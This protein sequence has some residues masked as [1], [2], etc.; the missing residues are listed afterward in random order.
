MEKNL[1]KKLRRRL[2]CVQCKRS[3]RKCDKLRPACSRCQQALLQCIYERDADRCVNTITESSKNSTS[4]ERVNN[5]YIAP[6]ERD[7]YELSFESSTKDLVNVP[8]FIWNVEDMLVILGSMTF[9]DYPFASHSVVEY[10]LY[11]RALCGSLHGMTLIDLSSRLNGLPSQDSLNRVL[12]PL[13]FIEKAIQRRIQFSKANRFQPPV[14]GLLYNGCSVEDDSL[15]D[16]LQTLAVEIE[17]LPMQKKDCDTLLKSFYQNIYPFH[18]FIDINSFEHDL[19]M[20][21]VEDNNHNWKISIDSKDARKKIETMSLLA[22][23]MAITLKHSTLDIDILSIV[24]ESASESAKKLSLLCHRLLCLLDVFRYPNES[25]FGC[26]LYFYISEHLDPDSPEVIVLPTE[27]LG[28]NHLT[29]LSMILGLQ[30][31]PCKYKRIQNPQ[32]IRRRRLLWFGIQSLRFQITL[33]EGNSDKTINEFMEASLADSESTK[34]SSNDFSNSMDEFY[35]QFSN[36]AWEKCKFH[37]L[38]NKLISSYTSIVENPLLFTVLENIRRSEDFM[39]E[40]FPLDLIYSPLNDPALNTVA[41]SKGSILNICDV[42]KTEV[43]MAN[44]VGRTCVFNT[45]NVLSLYFEKKCIIHWE[46][47]ENNYHYFTLRSF[48]VYLEV[49]GL[50]SDYLDTR[51]GGNIP[52]QND[53]VINKQVCFTLIRIW[54]FQSRILLRLSYKQE[55]EIKRVSSNDTQGASN[56]TRI[57]ARLI[58]HVRNQMTYLIGLASER[59]QQC[60]FGNFQAV[61][62]FRYI[63]YVVDAGKL[64]SVT[65]EFWERNIDQRKVPQNIQ[66]TVGL[67]WGLETKNSRAIKQKLTSPQTLESFNELLLRQMEGAVLSSSFGENSNSVVSSNLFEGAFNVNEDET[68]SELLESNFELFCDLL[69]KNMS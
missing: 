24:K 32:H 67:K 55:T 61:E 68:L 41:F 36:I 62:M 8:L 21:F 50:V 46:Q 17:S 38:L 19:A 2:V 45:L 31:D 27:L 43:F 64:V 56:M 65:N 28:L 63:V 18:P 47:Y 12:T 6:Y 16:V 40:H 37:I 57:L 20:L 4:Q 11:L 44:I 3:K 29:N 52:Q 54:L 33:P 59:L 23:I 58:Q 35:V 25:T 49:A 10:D 13:W 5:K 48:N 60:Y 22:I 39:L 30:Y 53:Y 15:A 42:K 1:V 7:G 69:G 14:L 34:S 9:M 51:F 26:L 66:Q